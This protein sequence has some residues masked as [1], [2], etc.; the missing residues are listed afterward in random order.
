MFCSAVVALTAHIQKVL[1]SNLK[2]ANDYL[3]SGMCGFTPFLQ[4]NYRKIH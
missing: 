2:L 3:H 4:I 1:G